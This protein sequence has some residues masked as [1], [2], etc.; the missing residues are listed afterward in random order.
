[1]SLLLCGCTPTAPAEDIVTLALDVPPTNLDPR[2]GIDATSERL[3]QL[4]FNSLVRK[5]ESSNLVPDL[6]ESWEISDPTTYIFHLRDGVRFHDGRPLGA[7][8][9]VYTFDSILNETIQTPK[10]SAYRR[11]SSVE[12]LDDRTVQFRLSQ[13]FAAF[14]WNLARGAI[15]IVPEGSGLE[16]A[17]HPIGSGP[18]VFDHYTR[19]AEIVLRRNADYF[20]Q[21][22]RLNAVRFKVVPEAIVRALELRKGSVDIALNVLPAD[23][24]EELRDS[25]GLRF[26]EGE[27][28]NYQY[29]AFNL[30][31]P[32]F[33]DV[34][35]RRA[36]AHA[37]DRDAI[38]ASLWRNHARLATLFSRR[39]TGR[40]LKVSRGTPTTR[41]GRAPFSKRRVFLVWSLPT[42]RRPMRRD[43]W[44]QP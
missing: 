17:D 19:D 13:P 37:V 40:I 27:G 29:L 26:M 33:N 8:D 39:T 1:M 22:P 3:T 20:G 21:A 41:I 34:R 7:R 32:T 23:M 43:S 15:G 38:V 16:M 14:L 11:I 31:D 18:F 9:V 5:D 44:S 25:P 2:I 30:K 28:T 4:I 35:V 42:G 10:A 36:I 24:A 12:A 6:A